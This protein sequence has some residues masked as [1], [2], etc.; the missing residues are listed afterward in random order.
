MNLCNSSSLAKVLRDR[1]LRYTAQR[2]LIYQILCR[3]REHLDAEGIWKAAQQED[4]RVNLATVYRNLHVLL[5]A[6]LVRQSYIGEDLKR[7]YYEIPKPGE[8]IHLVCVRCGKVLELES[9]RLNTVFGELEQEHQVRILARHIQL[10]G[11]CGDCL[12][13]FA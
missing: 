7:V 2:A 4:E 11:L 12:S 3:S 5:E 6:G 8:H 10:D 13:N 9:A 1:G